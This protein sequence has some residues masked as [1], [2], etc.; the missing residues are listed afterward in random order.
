[1]PSSQ[2]AWRIASSS[3]AVMLGVGSSSGSGAGAS[4]S[5]S[6]RYQSGLSPRALRSTSEITSISGQP[7][8]C[9]WLSSVSGLT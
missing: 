1:M 3:S 8:V 2:A 6:C 9:T 4:A 5:C 7:Q